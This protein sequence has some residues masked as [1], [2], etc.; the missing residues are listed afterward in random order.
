VLSDRILVIDNDIDF[1]KKLSSFLKEYE[2]INITDGKEALRYFQERKNIRIVLINNILTG[3]DGINI[4]QEL[5]ARHKD[6]YVFM[7]ST[8]GTKDLVIK[9]LRSNADDFI[10]KPVDIKALKEKIKVILKSRNV[11][12]RVSRGE[13]VD[14]IKRFI[15]RNYRT[16][17]L[18]FIAKE[19]FLSSKYVSKMFNERNGIS[20]RDYKVNFKIDKAKNLLGHTSLDINE[21]ASD[22]GYQNPESFMRIFKKITQ[23]TPGQYRKDLKFKKSNS[24]KP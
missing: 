18:E 11:L 5:K 2:I 21:I 24:M 19:L 15:S 12:S 20:F 14:R 7:M 9:A 13:N 1:A 10:D 6:I 4:L 22:L 23:K 17:T 8:H 3:V 16:A